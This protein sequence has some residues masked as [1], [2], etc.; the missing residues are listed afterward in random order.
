MGDPLTFISQLPD[1]V[2]PEVYKILMRERL[3]VHEVSSTTL[4]INGPYFFDLH[5]HISSHSS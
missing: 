2:I 1:K 3:L 4:K 5:G